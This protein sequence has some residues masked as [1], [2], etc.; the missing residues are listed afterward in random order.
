MTFGAVSGAPALV[1]VSWPDS[2]HLVGADVGG[3]LY[4]STDDGQTWQPR[5]VLDARPQALLAAGDG[6][7]YIAT[8]TA[9]YTSTDDGTTVNVLTAVE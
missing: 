4:T 1:L 5:H 3:R 6:E 9:I 2:G 7:V 8:D